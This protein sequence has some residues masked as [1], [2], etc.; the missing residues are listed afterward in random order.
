MAASGVDPIIPLGIV[1]IVGLAFTYLGYD[2]FDLCLTWIGGLVGAALGGA[3]GWYVIGNGGGPGAG[4]QFLLAGVL[5]LFGGLIGAGIVTALARFAIVVDAFV[6]STLAGALVFLG[7]GLF[8]PEAVPEN[9]EAVDPAVVEEVVAVER[10]V[11]GG[12]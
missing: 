2:L 5:A 8:R 11:Q 6:A 4:G 12:G 10:V 9:P 1:T 3:I 7:E